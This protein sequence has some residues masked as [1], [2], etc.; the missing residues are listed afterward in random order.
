MPDDSLEARVL[1]LLE[2]CG[3]CRACELASFI[4]T[5][6]CTMQ[7]VLAGMSAVERFDYTPAIDKW[8][9]KERAPAAAMTATA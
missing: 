3:P 4:G 6:T 5:D 1:F 2:R 7:S 9:L 8:R